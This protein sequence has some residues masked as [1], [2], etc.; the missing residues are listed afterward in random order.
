LDAV[1]T[2]IAAEAVTA[3]RGRDVDP[4]AVIAAVD[5]VMPGDLRKRA[6]A[7]G[8]KALATWGAST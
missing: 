1:A 6:L 3:A 2:R 4:A 8:R 5:V 7:E